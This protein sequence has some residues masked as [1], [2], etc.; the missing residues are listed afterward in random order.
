MPPRRGGKTTWGSYCS[1]DPATAIA[2]AHEQRAAI[3]RQERVAVVHDHEVVAGPVHLA[4]ADDHGAGATG[5]CNTSAGSSRSRATA[6]NCR[7]GF[8]LMMATV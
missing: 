3:E 7:N 1:L 8:S 5:R 6:G 2:P 4:E